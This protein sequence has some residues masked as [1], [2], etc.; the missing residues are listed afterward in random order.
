MHTIIHRVG[1]WE[2]FNELCVGRSSVT[3]KSMAAYF[4]GNFVSKIFYQNAANTRTN[5]K[6]TDTK[7]V[8]FSINKRRYFPF[9]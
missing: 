8:Q 4:A 9:S 7:I 5:T 1:G 2:N 3:K 6:T